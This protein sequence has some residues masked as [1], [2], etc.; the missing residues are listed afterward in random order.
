MRNILATAVLATL[1]FAPSIAAAQDEF[2]EDVSLNQFTTLTGNTEE[3]KG[4][5][6]E[7]Q[8]A[9][10][11]PAAAAATMPPEPAKKTFNVYTDKFNMTNHY[12][13]SGWMGDYGDIKF[14]DAC[15]ENPHSGKHCI[16]IEYSAQKAQGA[17]WM[18]IFWQNPANNWGD[19]QGG[20]DLTGYK[21]MTLWARGAKGGETIV[22]FKVG[23]ISGNYSD[24]DS[25]SIGPVTLTP[26]W[27][28][29]E[30]DLSGLDL[31]YISGG[32]AFSASANDNPEGFT[33]Y[34]DDIQYQQ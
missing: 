34:L 7:A 26:E 5:A 12:I 3:A 21:K 28:E 14:N 1:F 25:T 22:E 2:E 29:Y 27:K 10:P 9:K 31:S 20:Y 30:I 32:F 33:I 6:D 4:S 17:G 13:P 19:R 24:S 11:Q 15:N 8:S 23:G 16:K 18:G